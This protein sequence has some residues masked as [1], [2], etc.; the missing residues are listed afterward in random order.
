MQVH[1]RDLLSADS[2]TSVLTERRTQPA[3]QQAASSVPEALWYDRYF[4]S[5]N[6]FQLATLSFHLPPIFSNV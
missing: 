2:I 5:G 3:V 1:A 6:T 4:T